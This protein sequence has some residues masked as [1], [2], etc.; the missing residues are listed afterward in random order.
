M[1]GPVRRRT[2][3]CTFHTILVN[4]SGSVLARMHKSTA[5]VVQTH[6]ARRTPHVRQ[7]VL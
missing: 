1:H 7:M 3:I 4:N 5:M 2:V 6:D